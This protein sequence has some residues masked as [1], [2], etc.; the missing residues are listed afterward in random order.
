[1]GVD[2]RDAP[3]CVDEDLRKRGSV[4]NG[5]EEALF[6]VG[7]RLRRAQGRLTDGRVDILQ[8]F[9]HDLQVRF[10]RLEF[11]VDERMNASDRN[12]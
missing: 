6:G 10:I 12:G 2:E 1:M 7:I 3:A 4:D 8:G 5:V 9:E 11:T